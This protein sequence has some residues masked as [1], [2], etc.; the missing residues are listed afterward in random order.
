RG[1][2]FTDKHGGFDKVEVAPA[3]YTNDEKTMAKVQISVSFKDN[4][5]K[6]EKNISLIKVDGK[7]LI[8]M[9]I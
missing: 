6:D 2:A 5:K 1:K 7:W 4:T 9:K 8:N 3:E